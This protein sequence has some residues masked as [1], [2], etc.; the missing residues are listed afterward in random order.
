[1]LL[2]ENELIGSLAKADLQAISFLILFA[3]VSQIPLKISF[4]LILLTFIHFIRNNL[5]S[6]QTWTQLI[7]A[8]NNSDTIWFLS[9]NYIGDKLYLCSN[10]HRINSS[11]ELRFVQVGQKMVNSLHVDISRIKPE[12]SSKKHFKLFTSSNNK[13]RIPQTNQKSLWDWK[14][15]QSCLA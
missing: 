14:T 2:T 4:I 10:S 6:T 11:N 3:E 9:S 12:F 5:K 8:A 1:M 13:F 15:F 7:I